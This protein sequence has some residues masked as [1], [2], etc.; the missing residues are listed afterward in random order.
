MERFC[1]YHL[2][3]MLTVRTS[4]SYVASWDKSR[5]PAQ[6]KEHVIGKTETLLSEWKQLNKNKYNMAKQSNALEINEATVKEV[7]DNLLDIAYANVLSMI[8]IR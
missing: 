2:K 1:H 4:A 5:I 6:M 3:D 8:N 7:I